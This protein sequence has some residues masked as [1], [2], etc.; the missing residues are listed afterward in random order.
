MRSICV[1]A[2]SRVHGDRHNRR[3]RCDSPEDIAYQPF[4]KFYQVWAERPVMNVPSYRGQGRPP[5]K[6][7]ASVAPR[8]VADMA[9]DPDTAWK[10]VIFGEGSKGPT[11]GEVACLRVIECHEGRPHDAGLFSAASR[12]RSSTQSA[13]HQPI[14]LRKSCSRLGRG[15]GQLSSCSREAK[16]RFTC[17]RPGIAT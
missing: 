16:K 17:G 12:M 8:T 7:I 2:D 3:S 14:V 1:L 4:P 9:L 5:T 13:T 15:A 6:G 10:P 11:Y